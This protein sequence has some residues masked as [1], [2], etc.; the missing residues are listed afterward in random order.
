M[1]KKKKKKK[2]KAIVDNMDKGRKEGRRLVT[3]F[4]GVEMTN[5]KLKGWLLNV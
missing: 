3:K 5:Q 2:R 1:K 4:N